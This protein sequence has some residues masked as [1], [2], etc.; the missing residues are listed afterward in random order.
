MV[1]L[2]CFDKKFK[3]AQHYIGFAE[4]QRTFEI[5]MKHHAS[6]RGSRLMDAVTKAGIGFKVART[7]EDGDRNF[8]R[9]LKN[10]K[11][12]SR[13]CPHCKAK[14]A[15]VKPLLIIDTET[16]GLSADG[17]ATALNM[18]VELVGT[19]DSLV[20]DISTPRAKAEALRQKHIAHLEA[21]P[22]SPAMQAMIDELSTPQGFET[23]FDYI[24]DL[25]KEPERVSPFK[26]FWNSFVQWFESL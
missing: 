13:L 5:R 7:W 22:R 14:P 6:G 1:Y 21:N 16:G 15:I 25:G 4:N 18:S 11:N 20:T 23:A 8:E 12:A 26:K 10:Q 2:L 9:K 3:H 17:H 24:S 19:K